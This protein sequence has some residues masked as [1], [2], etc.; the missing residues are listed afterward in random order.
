[1]FFFQFDQVSVGDVLDDLVVGVLD[2]RGGFSGFD[3]GS[4][5]VF[6]GCGD[7]IVSDGDNSFYKK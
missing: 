4:L 5:S 7:H 3:H 1:M 6:N 2:K